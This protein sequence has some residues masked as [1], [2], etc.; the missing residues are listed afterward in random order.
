MG[1]ADY[2]SPDQVRDPR[3]PT[4]AWDIYSLG[5]TLYYAVTGKVPF[6]GG[7]TADKARAHCELRPLD[8][9][10]LNPRLAPEFVE[11]MADMMA[12]EPAQ[13]IA[14]AREVMAR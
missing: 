10:R 6:P 1:T 14:T 12:K 11:V 4:P 3:N 2:L 8:P 7:T 13:R 9:R 5:C